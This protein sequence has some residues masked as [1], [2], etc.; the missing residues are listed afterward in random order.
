MSK[1]QIIDDLPRLSSD[2]RRE[3]LE[4]IHEIDHQ[5]WLANDL[6]PEEIALIDQR[7]AA[8][9]QNPAVAIPWTEAEARL[10]KRFGE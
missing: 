4:K 2:E 5:G 3:I 9:Q 10:V 1:A 8:H 7:L 6:S